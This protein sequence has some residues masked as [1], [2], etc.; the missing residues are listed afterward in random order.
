MNILIC[1]LGISWQIAAESLGFVNRKTFDLYRNHPGEVDINEK[2]RIYFKDEAD[3]VW[4]LSTD[5]EKQKEQFNLLKKWIEL[6]GIDIAATFIPLPGIDDITNE[7][8]VRKFA[9]LCYKTVFEARKKV[10]DREKLYVS[11]AGG[12]KT[13]SSDLLD[14]VHIFGAD[15]VFHVI[16]DGKE[17]GKPPTPEELASSPNEYIKHFIPVV[18]GTYQPQ[19]FIA[20]IQPG[21][22]NQSLYELIKRIQEKAANHYNNS[23]DTADDN[24]RILFGYKKSVIEHLKNYKI[25]IKPDDKKRELDLLKKL[26]K[27]DLHCHLGGSLSIQE[28]IELSELYI[29]QIEKYK[30]KLPG[31]LEEFK[32]LITQKGG[33]KKI[34]IQE[35]PKHICVLAFV[36]LFNGDAASLSKWLYGDYNEESDF[37]NCNIIPYEKLGDIQGSSLFQTKEAISFAVRKLLDKSVAENVAYLEIRCS[38]IN[39]TRYGLSGEDVIKTICTEID[40]YNGRISVSLLIIASRHGKM[41]D[42]CRHIELVEELKNDTL[43]SRYFKG[44]DLAG[45]ETQKSP[46]EL[47][48]VFLPIMADCS[49]ITIH[50]GETVSE[51]NIWEAVYHLNAER[52][53]HG[54][55]L[56]D[57]PKLVEK[58]LDRNIGIEMCPSSNYQIRDFRDNYYE[59]TFNSPIYPLKEYLT[60]GLRV[61]V[62][63]DNTGI[64]RTNATNELHK[65]ARMTP[66]GLSLWEI[67]KIIK[68]GYKSAFIGFDDKQKLIKKAEADI[69]KFME[70]FLSNEK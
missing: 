10:A 9:E 48:D 14:A 52:I 21:L 11:I 36:K 46:K 2:R 19:E 1:T 59:E 53:G 6:T 54:L 17:K 16:D 43:F 20:D 69:E 42:I 26:P 56:K 44:F 64:S 37:R 45:D 35:V 30:N 51:Q 34:N 15:V 57:N 66:G 65:A 22:N 4:L 5:S 25:G 27:T 18:T 41:S 70:E 33:I 29:D 61:S 50:A 67:L 39:Y 12:R 58:I 13:M 23:I 60:R 62:N 3:E 63:T 24:F 8:S 55:T 31:D 40:I 68:N 32:N 7:E 47:R 28:I 38:P 49:N